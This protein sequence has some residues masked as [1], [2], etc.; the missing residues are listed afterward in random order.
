MTAVAD[1]RATFD[2]A[3][4]VATR[5]RSLDGV[6]QALD[7]LV[8]SADPAVVFA[9]VARACVPTVCAAATIQHIRLGPGTRRLSCDSVF[10]PIDVAPVDGT[11]SFRAVLQLRYDDRRPGSDEVAVAQI[12][13]DHAAALVDRERAAACTAHIRTE[14]DALGRA[15]TS[16]REIGVAMGILMARHALTGAQSFDL[17]RRASQR[18]NEKLHDL[19]LEVV[20]TG[21]LDLPAGVTINGADGRVPGPSRLRDL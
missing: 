1:S 9:S 12:V 21:Q 11:G 8:A 13:V 4:L 2:P 14:V 10:T 15:L 3:V 20:A 17:L 5:R 6:L 18:R 19:A 7:A 16:S